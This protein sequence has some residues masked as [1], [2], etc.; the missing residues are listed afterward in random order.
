M[1]AADNGGSEAGDRPADGPP[2]PRQRAHNAFN[3]AVARERAALQTHQLA[4]ERHEAMAAHYRNAAAA[5]TDPYTKDRLR[6]LE[7]AERDRA[8]QA[9]LRA[10]SVRERLLRDGIEP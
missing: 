5:A 3:D 4:A 8:G 6:S 10:Q 9:R 7:A 1:T 2:S